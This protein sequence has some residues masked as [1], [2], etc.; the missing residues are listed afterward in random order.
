MA[1]NLI[2]S[3]QYELNMSTIPPVFDMIDTHC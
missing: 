3:T 2:I 1:G